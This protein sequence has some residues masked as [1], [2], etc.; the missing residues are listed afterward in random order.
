MTEYGLPK[1]VT[2]N[3]KEYPIRTDFR[4]ILDVL[5]ALRDEE[6]EDLEKEYIMLTIMYPEG[7]PD[8]IEAAAQAVC[9]FIDAGQHEKKNAPRLMDWD[10]DYPLI[11][12][13]VNHVLGHEVRA[14]DYMHWWTFLAAYLEIGTESLFSSVI[15]IRS[16]KAKG[17]KLEKYEREF[18]EQNKDLIY[19]PDPNQAEND[20]LTEFV[21]NGGEL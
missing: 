9:D 11:I 6:L 12:A 19:L 1:T 17:K 2:I 7:I 14:D 18:A 5:A 21:R 8:D 10:K 3:G 4:V 16:K 13:G 20:A 15:S